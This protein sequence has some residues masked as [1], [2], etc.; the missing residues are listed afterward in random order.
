MTSFSTNVYILHRYL[1]A[2]YPDFDVI[3]NFSGIYEKENFARHQVPATFSFEILRD[4]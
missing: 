3:L 4:N 2:I 1:A